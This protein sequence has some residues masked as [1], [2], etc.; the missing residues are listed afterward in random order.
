MPAKE[1]TLQEFEEKR[2]EIKADIVSEIATSIKYGYA[3]FLKDRSALDNQ[4]SNRPYNA[5]NGLAMEGM[6]SLLANI[7]KEK[8]HTL[9]INGF[10]SM[11]HK[12]WAYQ[13]KH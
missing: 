9:Q 6:N 4:K 13:K 11:M 8:S 1:M 10:L 5:S 3:P 2:A 7:K 12:E